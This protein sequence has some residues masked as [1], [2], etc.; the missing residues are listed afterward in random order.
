[1]AA[2]YGVIVPY[3]IALANKAHIKVSP[4]VHPGPEIWSRGAVG[5][6]ALLL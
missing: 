1:M 4:P 6:M 2:S 5:S 3:A